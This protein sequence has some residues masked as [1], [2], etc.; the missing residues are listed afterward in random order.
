MDA[1]NTMANK[2]AADAPGD[3]IDPRG[4]P[5]GEPVPPAPRLAGLD[6]RRVLLLDNG[7]LA[8]TMG[9]YAVLA[10]A[11][12]TGL[13]EAVWTQAT[14]NLLRV[15]DADVEGLAASLIA[16]HR[17]D[18]CVL[19][20]ADAGVTAHTALLT[21]ALERRG[22]P[23]VMLATP[24]G[25]GLGRA[26][27]RA[28]APGLDVVVLDTVRS[29][30]QEQVRALVAA[31]LPRIGALLTRDV[32]PAAADRASDRLAWRNILWNFCPATTSSISAAKIPSA[33]SPPRHGAARAF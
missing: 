23:A 13:P 3:L 10:D 12:R 16:T 20:L 22:I 25:A 30:S 17:P 5:A 8:A 33:P 21:V 14:I 11:L 24:L 26:I 28:R 15:D 19:A 18:A 31:E 7:K 2:Q 29:D 6:G 9:P 4:I 1:T 27:L 32:T